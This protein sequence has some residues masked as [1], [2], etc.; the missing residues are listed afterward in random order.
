MMPKSSRAII[1]SLIICFAFVNYASA[2]IVDTGRVNPSLDPLKIVYFGSSV[3]FGYG[4]T[5]N[6][7]YT[8]RFNRI[9]QQRADNGTGKAWKPVNKSIGGDNTIR[10]RNR[11]QKDLV[12]QKA[13][14][15]VLALSL[16][17]EGLHESGKIK[18]DQ[19]KTNITK[20]IALARDSGYVPVL[21]NCYTRNDF[22][23]QDYSYTQQMDMWIH[24]LDVPSINLLGGVDN[25]R[26]NWAPAYW[27]D[28][29]HPNDA[30]HQE[31]AYTIVPSLF[32]ALSNGK[33][34]PKQIDTDNT[35]IHIQTKQ[36][37]FKPDNIVHPFT[38]T[39]TVKADGRGCILQL[40]DTTGNIGAIS[41]TD[42]GLLQ[43]RSPQYQKITGTMPVNDGK[44]HTITLTHYYARN[45]TQL[46]CDSTLQGAVN[47][48]I[49][50]KELYA[51]ATDSKNITARNWLF[52]RAGMNATEV[53]ALT[54]NTL[55]KSS[56]E[57]YAPL[58]E[59]QDVLKNL[60]QSTDTLN[61]MK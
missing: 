51:G 41:I 24:T 26:G 2:G 5:N 11:W 50:V 27:H 44:W 1:T 57:L 42:K 19:F 7:G 22:N 23:A 28:P 47:E 6:F 49:L 53:A 3:P 61:W 18:F 37:A 32:D 12:P 31:L 21:T 29:G 17:N 34:Q 15:V 13:K 35:G 43:Y 4:A 48:Q 39:I 8:Y 60:A 38:T 25:G 20:L 40:K 55:L 45:Q 36:I 58:D 59:K 54:N 56:L 10:L 52:Y 30:G 46:Y 33:P 14:Y 9:L 16:G